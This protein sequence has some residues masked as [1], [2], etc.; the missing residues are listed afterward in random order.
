MGKSREKQ[1]P[2]PAEPSASS[3][4]PHSSAPQSP[5]PPDPLEDLDLSY[6]PPCHAPWGDSPLDDPQGG[7]TSLAPERHTSIADAL[8]NRTLQRILG[9]LYGRPERTFHFSE[10]VEYVGMGSGTVQRRLE[11]LEASGHILSRRVG[12]QRRYYTNTASP[13]HEEL[14]AL[15]FKTIGI[16]DPLREALHPLRRHIG[17]AFIRGTVARGV[18][19]AWCVISVVAIVDGITREQVEERLGTVELGRE[20][21]LTFHTGPDYLR[22]LDP[23]RRPAT[24][25]IEE[26]KIFLFGNQNRVEGAM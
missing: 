1:S 23:P 19:T 8:F 25:Y 16:A 24:I 17:A 4:L 14:C 20:V 2:T 21:H 22:L 9:L 11:A 5:E 13:V 15:A 10:I 3:E 18:D 12:N 7:T 6:A 26:P